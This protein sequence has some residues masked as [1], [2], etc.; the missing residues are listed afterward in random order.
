MTKSRQRGSTLFGVIFGLVAGL[1]VALVVAIYVTKVPVPFIN[2]GASR[3]PLQDEAEAERNRNWNPNAGLQS[4]VGID[5]SSNPA[6]VASGS[7]TPPPPPATGVAGGAVAPAP[8]AAPGLVPAEVPRPTPQFPLSGNLPE[9]PPAA[10]ASGSPA[11][12]AGGARTAPVRPGQASAADP[13]GALMASR[14]PSREPGRANG[15]APAPDPFLYF[16]QAGAFRSPQDADAQRA[17][18]SLLGVEARV[19]EREQS[20]RPVYRVR[21]GPFQDHDTANQVQSQLASNGF[22]AALVRVQR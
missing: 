20:G 5:S 18:L 16:V 1:A 17:R 13:L 4:P 11:H 10:T 3:S 21:A 19:S 14:T 7:V 15:N 12:G 2:R 6:G 22:D 9:L 8:S